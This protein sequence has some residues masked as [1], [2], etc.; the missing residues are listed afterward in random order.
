[1][2]DILSASNKHLASNEVWLG[3]ELLSSLGSG[4]SEVADTAI[5]IAGENDWKHRQGDN[6][7]SEST[8]ADGL[9]N[10]IG[11]VQNKILTGRVFRFNLLL[12]VGRFWVMWET[13]TGSIVACLLN[14]NKLINYLI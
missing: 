9:H 1:M 12:R 8:S 2:C 13:L 3:F 7:E 4:E 14:K 10:S 6:S 11:L 5:Q